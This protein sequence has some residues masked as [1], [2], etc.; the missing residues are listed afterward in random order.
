MTDVE[1]KLW[2]ALRNRGLEGYKFRSQATIGPFV[3]DF[4][5]IEAA[6]IVEL[7]GGQ[8]SE[9]ADARRTAFLRERGYRL[10]RFWNND[11]IESFDGVL[12]VIAATLADQTERR[13]SPNPL[14]QAGE[15]KNA[16]G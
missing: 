7:D 2:S 4:L 12:Q 16:S 13:P 9:A 3:A 15:G 8:H 14:P 6:L 11:V 10:I 5:C 1:H